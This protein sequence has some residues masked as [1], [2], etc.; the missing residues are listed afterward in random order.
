MRPG[1]FIAFRYLFAKKSHN[2]INVISA[3]S[4]AGIAIGT[5]ALILIL[6]VCN[7]FNGIIESNLSDL[8]PDITISRADGNHFSTSNVPWSGILK[9]TSGITCHEVLEEEIFITYGKARGTATAKGV[10]NSYLHNSGLSRHVISGE[11]TIYRNGIP[12]AMVGASLASAMGINPRFLEKVELHYPSDTPHNPLSGPGL[13]L[14]SVKVGVS[15]LISVNESID[16]HL[17]I[18]PIETVRELIGAKDDEVSAIELTVPSGSIK[19]R[20]MELK[21]SLGS[22]YKVQDR[23]E[24]NSSVFKMMKYEKFTVYLILLFVVVIIAFNIFGSLSMLIIEKK[25]D[26]EMLC[27]MGAKDSMR[28]RIFVM[29]GWMISLVG[30]TIGLAVG[31]ILCIVQQKFG[32]VKM[33]GGFAMNAY[34]VILKASD[35]LFTV[36]GVSMSGLAISLSAT[37]KKI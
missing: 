11:F 22:E 27:S 29:E 25:D 26:M 6:S 24:L 16:S 13:S 33:P 1:P 9:D 14:G 18:V 4:A 7:G 23:Y 37:R 5:A 12:R 35:I 28:K 19:S 15:A 32:L 34:P 2:V 3:I 20:I 31:L 30:M 8:D 36:V 10:D 21:T 17:M